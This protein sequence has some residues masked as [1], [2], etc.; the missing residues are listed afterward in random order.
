MHISTKTISSLLACAPLWLGI[1]G[2]AHAV[3]STITVTA[4]VVADPC[5]VDTASQK[6]NIDLGKLSAADL[7]TAGT[8]SAKKDFG[9]TL[10]CPAGT[11]GVTYTFAGTA[12]SSDTTSFKNEGTASHVAVRLY[13]SDGQAVISP[14]GK[15]VGS[16]NAT[17]GPVTHNFKTAVYSIGGV[18]PGTVKSTITVTMTYS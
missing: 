9:L 3:D 2:T 18:L 14:G 17:G 10:N 15:Y 8:L 7:A 11:T 1:C 5:T 13:Q 4:T 12:D 6:M 16:M